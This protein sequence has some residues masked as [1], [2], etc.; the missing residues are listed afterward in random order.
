MDH[1]Y[2]LDIAIYAGGTVSFSGQ[3]PR[4][5]DLGGAEYCAVSM[6]ESLTRCGHRVT[7]FT[8]YSP[9]VYGDG[10]EITVNAVKYMS[11]QHHWEMTCKS[12]L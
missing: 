2:T 11:I 7:V 10:T 3:T 9:A 4:S 5:K 12:K 1:G 6:A 8:P